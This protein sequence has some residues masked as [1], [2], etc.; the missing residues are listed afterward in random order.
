MYRRTLQ[1]LAAA[2]LWT[3]SAPADPPPSN[4]R[5]VEVKN[6]GLHIGGGPN[7]TATKKPYQDALAR[8][9]DAFRRCHAKAET[10]EGTFGVDLLVPAEGGPPEVSE[11]RTGMKGEAFRACI[12]DA[13]RQADLPGSKRGA[14]RISYSLKFSVAG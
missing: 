4:D 13:F 7:D 2:S 10:A 8:Q 3:G 9:F 12:V 6:I 14:V 1:L 11:P 5:P